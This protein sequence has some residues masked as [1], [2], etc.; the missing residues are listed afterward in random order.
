MDRTIGGC[1]TSEDIAQPCVEADVPFH[2]S[3]DRIVN[4]GLAASW[5]RACFFIRAFQIG[6]W[7]CLIVAFNFYFPNGR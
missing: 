3:A 6:V 7:G 1:L 2:A 4:S 5:G